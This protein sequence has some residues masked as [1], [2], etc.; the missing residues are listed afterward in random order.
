MKFDL[1]LKEETGLT[2]DSFCPTRWWSKWEIVCVFVD[3]EPFLK[4]ADDF[5]G[6]TRAKLLEYFDD[7]VKT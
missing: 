5:S 4:S 6:S 1:Q 7:P 2:V 3:I